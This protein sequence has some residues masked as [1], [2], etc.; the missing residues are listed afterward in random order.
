[1]KL[2]I[3]KKKVILGLSGGVDSAVALYKLIEDGYDVIAVFMRNWDS[4]LNRDILGNPTADDEICPQEKD[5]QDAKK[6][7]DKL[8]V[9]LQRVDFVKEYW[10]RVF[11]YFLNEYKLN[12]TPNPDVLCNNEIKF[13]AFLDYAMLK[14]VD[15]IAMG[16]YARVDRSSGRAKLLRGIDQN[17][18][19][20]YFLSQLT[21]E[22]LSKVLFPVG[23]LNKDE[24]RR[25]AR[26]LDL[27]VKDKK[28]STGICFIGERDFN[29][30]LA[31]Y[32][33]AKPGLMTRLDGTVIG[34]HYGLMNY[35]IGQRKGLGIGTIDGLDGPWFVVGK[36]LETNI[37]LIENKDNLDYLKS[38]E[39]I[40]TNYVWRACKRDGKYTA[41]FRYRQKD[42]AVY[43]RFLND[44]EFV[45]T[46]NNVSAVTPGQVCAIYD[47]D[48]CVGSGFINEVFY[49]GERR[50]YS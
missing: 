14:D 35:T 45:V 39:A 25:I 7:A 19:Q 27:A 34:K 44:K 10:D 12:R 2:T 37:L 38:D 9:E 31:N 46:Y 30:F 41:K 3:K 24:V 22:Q 32:L 13:K 8:G 28:D 5:Y 23:D 49:Q 40:I 11:T 36:E 43:V 15:Y 42:V 18:D 21:N 6:V 20:S 1:M 4:A 16:H 17:K 50:R 48:E 29:K 47:G 26:K 33:P